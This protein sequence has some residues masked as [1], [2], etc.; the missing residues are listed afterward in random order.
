MR[1]IS[2]LG[3]EAAVPEPSLAAELALPASKEPESGAID[4][5]LNI[6]EE[7]LLDQGSATASS[8]DFSPEEPG[9]AI[10]VGE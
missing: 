10:G 1:W 7:P 2:I 6:P 9:H 5:D 8:P 3:T 4:F